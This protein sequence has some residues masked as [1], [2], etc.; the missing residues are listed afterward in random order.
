M[1]EK[2]VGE[3][4]DSTSGATGRIIVAT[5]ASNIHRIQQIINSAVKIQQKG[6]SGWAEHA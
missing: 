1:S 5:F 6:R 2:T 3:T 4:F